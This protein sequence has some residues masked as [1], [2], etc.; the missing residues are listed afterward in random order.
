MQPKPKHWSADYAA[1]FKDPSVVSAYPHRPPYPAE[2]FEVLLS[3]ASGTPGAVLDV[4]CGTGDLARR[5]APLVRRVD[6]VDQSARMIE[7][8]KRLLGGDDPRLRWIVSPVESAP[9]EPPYQLV[10]A[11]ES[12]HWMDWDIVLP[13]FAENLVPGGVLAVVERDWDNRD[14]LRQ[15]LVPIFQRFGANRDYRPTDLIAELEQRGL[16]QRLGERVTSPEP[17]QPTL[18]EYLEC[19]YSQNGFDRDRMT[20]DAAAG[21]DAAMRAA[22]GD[23]VAEGVIGTRGDRLELTVTAKIVWGRPLRKEL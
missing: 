10:T 5:L 20:L 17:W 23:L 9:L 22:L 21:F 7:R 8:G 6:A 2:V 13:R 19:R 15:R 16:F 12:L 18:D 3:L 1:W 14:A 4:G 11:G